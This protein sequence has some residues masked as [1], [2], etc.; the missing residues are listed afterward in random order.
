VT[1]FDLRPGVRVRQARIPPLL[2]QPNRRAKL[3]AL[4]GRLGTVEVVSANKTA[5]VQWD[6]G[7][8][9]AWLAD[10]LDLA[11]P[12]AERPAT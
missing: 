5:Y 11:P 4:V 10:C 12:E 6:D 2:D 1:P 7:S 3:Q 8:S 9:G